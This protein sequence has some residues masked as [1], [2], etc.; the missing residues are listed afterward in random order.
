[1]VN[2][3][4]SSFETAIMIILFGMIY[5]DYGINMVIVVGSSIIIMILVRILAFFNKIGSIFEKFNVTNIKIMET[6]EDSDSNV[7]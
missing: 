1:M 2:F 3:I 5:R 7:I 6:D 4:R